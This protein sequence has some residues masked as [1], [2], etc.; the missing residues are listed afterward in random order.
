MILS[1]GF[2]SLEENYAFLILK[3]ALFL[4]CLTTVVLGLNG[5]YLWPVMM[6]SLF[7]GTTVVA[8]L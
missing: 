1:R 7:W 8:F 5:V 6:T 3:P 2:K 4:L